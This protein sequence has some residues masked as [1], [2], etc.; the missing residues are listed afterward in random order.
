[1]ENAVENHRRGF[2][3][4]GWNACGHLVENRAKGEQ[5]RA[6][7]QVFAARLFGRHV[8]DR[9]DGRTR[10]RQLFL[11]QTGCGHSRGTAFGDLSRRFLRQSEIEN[12]G[13]PAL[14][15]KDVS[16]LDIAMDDAFRMSRIER[17]GQLDREFEEKVRGQR[18]SADSTVQGLA[19]EQFHGDKLP[20][21]VL[22]N[23][24]NRTDVGM[25]QRR[26]RPRFAAKT[27]QRLWVLG[28]IGGQELKGDEASQRS[29]FGAVDNAHASLT[30]LFQHAK[31]G[32][33]RADGHQIRFSA[34]R[35][36]MGHQACCHL[37]CRCCNEALRGPFVRQ[38]RFHFMAQVFIVP[39]SILQKR[40]TLVGGYL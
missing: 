28:S 24:V 36:I 29:I 22:H 14:S 6:C 39:T 4:E 23:F 2:A 12:L 33:H 21:V 10:T 5:V 18:L 15:D 8:G 31:M 38:Q 37:E 19:L 9:A 13:L 27:L 40:S 16:W 3:P 32:D 11:R 30:Q 17:V 26:R 34:T 1:M 25:V 35:I 7:I 20:A